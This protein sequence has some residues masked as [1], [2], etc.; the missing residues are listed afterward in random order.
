MEFNWGTGHHVD[1]VHIPLTMLKATQKLMG[2]RR[3]WLD[4]ERGKTFAFK[5]E[6]LPKSYR[7]T[8]VEWWRGWSD[9]RD[10]INVNPLWG[11][12]ER[13]SSIDPLWR[14]TDILKTQNSCPLV[15][16]LNYTLFH[17]HGP[18]V[19][20]IVTDTYYAIFLENDLG[21]ILKIMS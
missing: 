9:C 4:R 20:P 7:P 12:K 2:I 14:A 15:Y 5:L 10:T 8:G 18:A 13:H 6:Q 3:Y 16:Y 21:N 17:H 19:V 11:R 1:K